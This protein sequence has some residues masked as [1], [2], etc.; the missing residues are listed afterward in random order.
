MA[1]S[2]DTSAF[3]RSELI[4]EIANASDLLFWH[5]TGRRPLDERTRCDILT[6]REEMVAAIDAGH[7]RREGGAHAEA[8][9][10]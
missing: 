9:P 2:I 1:Q 4:M 5:Y 10:C 7:Y 8:L 3:T 6:M